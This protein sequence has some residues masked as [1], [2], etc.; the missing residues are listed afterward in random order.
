[1]LEVRR[2]RYAPVGVLLFLL[3]NCGP[4]NAFTLNGDSHTHVYVIYDS[5]EAENLGERAARLELQP[6][7]T[8]DFMWGRKGKAFRAL[9]ADMGK[10]AGFNVPGGTR[11]KILVDAPNLGFSKSEFLDGPFK[12]KVAWIPIGSFDDPRHAMP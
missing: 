7:S 5:A 1:M 2:F 9:H 6:Q 11:F 3:T 10:Q 12:G 4:P 8:E